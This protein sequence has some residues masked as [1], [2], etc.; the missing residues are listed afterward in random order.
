MV[1]K[2]AEVRSVICTIERI[3]IGLLSRSLCNRGRR[4]RHASSS[5]GTEAIRAKP[6]RGSASRMRQP[7]MGFHCSNLRALS[8]LTVVSQDGRA[9]WG[10]DTAQE[11]AEKAPRPARDFS[12]SAARRAH[13]G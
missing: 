7:Q 4:I 8:V 9:E 13:E 3:D 5:C 11:A 6:V 1:I 10:H 12:A 2:D